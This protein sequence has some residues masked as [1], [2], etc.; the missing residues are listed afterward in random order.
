VSALEYL[1]PVI[2]VC[3]TVGVLCLGLAAYQ[4]WREWPDPRSWQSKYGTVRRRK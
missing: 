2:A 3:V 4:S 1:A